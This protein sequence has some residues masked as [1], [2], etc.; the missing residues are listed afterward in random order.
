MRTK[1]LP[2]SAESKRALIAR[3]R[4]IE[5]Q[6]RGIQSMVDREEGCEQVLQQMAAA[7]KALERAFL[8]AV[9]C[10]YEVEARAEDADERVVRT[11]HAVSELLVKYG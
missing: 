4:R 3:L 9:A 1:P 7:R 11:L 5:G 10:A 6:L 2:S 8:A